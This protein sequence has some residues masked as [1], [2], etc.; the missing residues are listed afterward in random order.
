MVIDLSKINMKEQPL[1]LL[2]NLND[3]IIAPLNSAM[4]I[5]GSLCYNEISM[6]SFDIPKFYNNIDVEGYDSICGMRI[7][8]WKDIGQFVLMNP[9][10]LDEGIL[11]KKQCKMYSLEYE[12]TYKKIS[13]ENSTYNFWNPATPK[14]TILGIVLSYMPSWSVGSV[15]SKLVGKYRTFEVDNEN[16]YDFMKNTLQ[17]TYCCVFEFDTINRVVNVRDANKSANK[18]AVYLSNKNLAKE[19]EIE[20][21]TENIITVLDVNG[22]DGVTIRSVNPIGTN[23][24]YNLDYF[25]NTT[26]FSQS[27][28]DKW[29]EWKNTYSANQELYYNVSLNQSSQITR[30]VAENASLVDMQGEL[31]NLEA[32]QAVIIQAIAQGLENQSELASINSKISSQTIKIQ[33]QKELLNE[34]EITIESITKELVEINKQTSIEAAFTDE[35]GNKDE[36]ALKLLDRYFKEESITDSSFVAPTVETYTDSDI[37][38]NVS[39]CNISISDAEVS[40]VKYADKTFYS[41]R[42]GTI[43]I[44]N[45]GFTV[46]AAIIKGTFEYNSDKSIIFSCYLDD[47]TIND[48]SFE[49]GNLSLTGASQSI[50][51][52]SSTLSSILSYASCYFTKNVTDYEQRQ[53]E[54]DL[55]EYG[56][57]QL[58][59]MSSPTYSFK[60]SLA[61][62]FAL[63]DYRT[64]VNEISLG[65]KI[66]L[67]TTMGVITPIVVCVDLDFN[68]IEDLEIEFGSTFDIN[69]STFDLVDLVSQSVS[70]GKSVDF[71]K[72]NY[73]KFID[74]GAESSV[75]TFMNSALDVAKNAILSSSGQAISWDAAGLRLRKWLNEEEGTYEPEQIWMANNSIMFTQDNW[76]NAVIGIGKFVDKNLGSCYGIVAPN[77]VGTLLTGENLVI[78]SAKQD[79]EISVFKVD[80]DGA[81]LY[82]SDFN[83]VS[84]G[85]QITLNADHG[86]GIGKYPLYTVDSEG[87]E[88]INKENAKFWVDTDGNLHINGTLEGC[89]GKFSGELS[90]ATGTFSGSLSAVTG[91]FKGTLDAGTIKGGTIK[92]GGTEESPNFY[93]DSA[94][95]LQATS[96]TFSGTVKGAA[97]QT[98]SG[99]SMMTNEQF[100]SAYLNLKGMDIKNSSNATTFA[101]DQNGDVTINGNITMNGG[102][103][104]WT[105]V[106]DNGALEK[107]KSAA[108]VAAEAYGAASSAKSTVSGWCYSGTTYIDGGKIYTGTVKA[109]KLIGGEVSLMTDSEATAGTMSIT[110]ASSATYAVEL[111]SNGALRL[112]GSYGATY[113]G[114]GSGTYL[115]LDSV[116]RLGVGAL[117]VAAKSYGYL[118]AMPTSGE[119]GQIYFAYTE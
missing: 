96:G 89:D 62:F 52:G 49:S 70:M 38:S 114:S 107:A 51:N 72:Y 71:N 30:Y 19:I 25:M 1:L 77:L 95:K 13:L 34:I 40:S 26:N 79:G 35:N 102:S 59:R 119:E 104:N 106:S 100:T 117:C 84:N 36:D 43:K 73:N 41:I 86:I 80:G 21:D 47:G 48:E 14:S 63:D 64:F 74:S 65:E 99:A 31:S 23:K 29:N 60:V 32:Q 108:S 18:K 16:L 92:I 55:Y 78:E 61:N 9:V 28:I 58:K 22:A 112:E 68:K 118:S 105:N 8:E 90:A 6:M 11:E 17:E 39:N 88:T 27:I 94:G 56:E 85:T 24:I 93:V 87:N 20:E 75:R 3:Q 101:V 111:K 109:S 67:E 33:K 7:V 10:I 54:W 66:Y 53:I 57:E 76:E 116:C 83:I 98:A 97:Y 69:S 81:H 42:G 5:K 115:Q 103:I 82:N 46:D 44:N 45:S 37:Y 15:D 113:V 2:K 110:G 91:T 4:N 12:F 50:S